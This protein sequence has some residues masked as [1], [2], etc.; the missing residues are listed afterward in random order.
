M[1]KAIA[2]AAAG[3]IMVSWTAGAQEQKAG[4]KISDASKI[5]RAMSAA[6]SRSLGRRRSWMPAPTVR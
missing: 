4:A 3:L 2:T 6:P 1:R 5:A